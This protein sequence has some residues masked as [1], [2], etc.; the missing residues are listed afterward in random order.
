[1]RLV[2]LISTKTSFDNIRPEN[3]KCII[4]II[5]S[6]EDLEIIHAALEVLVNLNQ[7]RIIELSDRIAAFALGPNVL[8]KE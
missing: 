7:K 2:S 5:Q 6:S 3:V 4:E 8:K 1:M